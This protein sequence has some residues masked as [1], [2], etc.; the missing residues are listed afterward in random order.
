MPHDISKSTIL[1]LAL[2]G[3]VALCAFG[4]YPHPS[5]AGNSREPVRQMLQPEESIVLGMGCFWGAEK[6]M[7][8]L[9]G[10]VDVVSG[11]AGGDYS[12]PTYRQVIT[13]EH[14]PD[15]I[16]HAEVVRVTFDPMVT[17]V[18]QVLAGF[19]ENHNPT[20]GD[21]QGNDIGSNYRS[22]IFYNSEAQR[23]AALLT[24]DI[25]QKALTAA[26]LGDITTEIAPLRTFYPAEEYHQDYLVKH[27]K[28]YCGL[29]GTQVR[30]PSGMKGDALTG[31]VPGPLDAEKLSNREQVVVFEAAHCPFCKLFRTEVLDNWKSPVPVVSSF[32]PDPPGG[33]TL[34]KDLWATPT[35]VLFRDGKEVNRYTGYNG[36]KERFWE[37]LD[38]S[39]NTRSSVAHVDEDQDG[40]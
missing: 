36:G 6:R 18:E 12:D 3:M 11:Y 17:S 19:W 33:W 1:G 30:F 32:S 34:E 16:N 35:I 40:R 26:G 2:T 24:R 21:R 29:G 14:Y 23:N 15:V 8:A 38:H 9:P 4:L 31:E 27:P 25:Y 20:Q 5:A 22:A 39:R 28:G 37:W 13:A 7:T 10:V